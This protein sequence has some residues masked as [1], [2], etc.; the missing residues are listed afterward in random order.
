MTKD[1]TQ[2]QPQTQ[3]RTLDES[4]RRNEEVVPCS[5]NIERK[6][7]NITNTRPSPPNPYR[8]DGKKNEEK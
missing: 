4:T 6:N 7:F 8:D 5:G 3:P 1:K 2:Q